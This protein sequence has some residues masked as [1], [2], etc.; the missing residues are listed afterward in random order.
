MFPPPPAWARDITTIGVTGTNGKTSTCAFLAAALRSIGGPV[1]RITTVGSFLD[2]ERLEVT[3]DHDG[4]LRALGACREAGGTR[5]V[6]EVTSEALAVGFGRA[7]PFKA[8]VFTNLSRDHLDAHGSLEHYLA[9]KAQL[10]LQ[11][12]PG[13]IAILPAHDPAAALIEEVIPAGVRVLRW[14]RACG[15]RVPEY[16]LLAAVPS[17]EGTRA[18]IWFAGRTMWLNLQAIGSEYAEN[19][20]AAFAAAVALG[21]GPELAAAGIANEPAPEGRFQVIGNHPRV[22]VDYAHTPDAIS[23]TLA[24]ARS[25]CSGR[26]AIVFGAGGRRDRGKRAGMGRA[27]SAADR[28]YLTTDNPR[29]ES[30]A[31]IAADVRSGIEAIGQLVEEPNR[32]EAIQRA[33]A[34]AEPEDVVVIAGKGHERVQ[35]VGS[36]RF[37]F[38]DVEEARRGLE[39]RGSCGRSPV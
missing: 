21:A 4:F 11:L 39:Q 26:V 33:I 3:D 29:D 2:D 30:A 23:R 5:A 15:A 16:A 10:F 37:A 9:S 22:V 18:F 8:A 27:A 31:A 34:E 13:A 24:T 32:R 17:W 12:P 25:L 20:T 28:I 35:I 6:L 38:S 7:W 14:G 36:D 1:L 19:A